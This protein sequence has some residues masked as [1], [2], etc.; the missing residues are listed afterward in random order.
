MSDRISRDRAAKNP[1]AMQCQ[2][3]D[4]IF[5]G[6]EWHLLCAICV[7]LRDPSKPRD[8]DAERSPEALEW[9]RRRKIGMPQ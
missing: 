9:R 7:K 6:E 2:K 1:G 4:E 3:C 8:L 5:I